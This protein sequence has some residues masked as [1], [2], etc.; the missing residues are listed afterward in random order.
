MGVRACVLRVYQDVAFEGHR[1]NSFWGGG[2]RASGVSMD[3]LIHN[4]SAKPVTRLGQTELRPGL[5]HLSRNRF[6][7]KLKKQCS[8]FKHSISCDD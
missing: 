7:F 5:R 6:L 3:T 2:Q 4:D 8:S 1:D